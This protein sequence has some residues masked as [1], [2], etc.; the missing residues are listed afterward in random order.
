MLKENFAELQLFLVIAR[1][2]SF[3]KA[4]AN[5]ACHSLRSAMR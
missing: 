2:R 3:T 1:E 5:L 4:A